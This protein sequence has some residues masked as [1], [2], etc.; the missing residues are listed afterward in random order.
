MYMHSQKCQMV[1][2]LLRIHASVS[3]GL[4]RKSKEIST[5]Q[6]A[7]LNV[8]NTN[9]THLALIK[10]FLKVKFRLEEEGMSICVIKR[11][12][13]EETSTLPSLQASN[14]KTVLKW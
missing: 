4:P 9:K 14:R 2:I 1:L 10:D 11:A 8:E 5:R 6:A 7:I 12:K 13:I 3:F